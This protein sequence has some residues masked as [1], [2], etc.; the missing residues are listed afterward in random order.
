MIT[1]SSRSKPWGLWP[2]VGFGVLIIAL[3][4]VVQGIA[5]VILLGA[6]AKE[7]DA[8]AQGWVVAWA[9]I[10]SA[11]IAVGAPLVLAH[12]RKGI[13]V[14]A[15]LGLAWPRA[16]QALRWSLILLGFIAACDSLSLALGRPLVPEPMLSMYRTAGPLPIFLIGLVVA[17]PLARKS[18]SSEGSFSLALSTPA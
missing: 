10:I 1:I 15:Y 7:N 14:A 3:W 17:A 11:P 4:A 9:T 12:V 13:S 16:L 18:F 2:T 5:T 6:G 8:V